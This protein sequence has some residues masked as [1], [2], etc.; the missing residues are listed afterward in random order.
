VRSLTLDSWTKKDLAHMQAWGNDRCNA[1]WEQSVP[2]EW[3][4][5][6]PDGAAGTATRDEREAWVRAK[7]AQLLFSGDGAVLSV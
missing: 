5:R 2:P 1:L 6:K 7:Y 4:A 3:A